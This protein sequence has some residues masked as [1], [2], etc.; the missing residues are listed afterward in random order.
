MVRFD[1][2]LHEKA[3][4]LPDGQ[5]PIPVEFGCIFCMMRDGITYHEP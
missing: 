4:G 5:S 3:K 2:I 1:G